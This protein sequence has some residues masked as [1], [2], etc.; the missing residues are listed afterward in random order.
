MTVNTGLPGRSPSLWDG[1]GTR[2]HLTGWPGSATEDSDREGPSIPLEARPKRKKSS[3]I[4][5]PLSALAV[6]TRGQKFSSFAQPETSIYNGVLSFSERTYENL[7]RDGKIK[8][9]LEAH[10]QR[11]L[12]RVYPA[13]YRITSLNFDPL[14]VW[15]LLSSCTGSFC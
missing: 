3:K 5:A 12:V 13:A 10:A 2:R 8:A 15:E 6:Y 11:H 14:K 4:S 9:Q 1:N 7:C